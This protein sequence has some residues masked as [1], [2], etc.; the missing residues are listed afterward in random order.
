[1]PLEPFATVDDLQERWRTL[2][3]EETPRA[4]ILLSDASN[5]IRSESGSSFSDPDELTFE[6][7]KAITCEMVKRAMQ[8][9]VDQPALNSMQQSGGSYSETL[10]FT[11]PSGDLYMTAKERKRLG[12]GTQKAFTIRPAIHDCAGGEISDW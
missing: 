2:T 10:N 11:N 1:M 4:E 5:I 7:L 9:P 3:A 12:I 6:V 8:S